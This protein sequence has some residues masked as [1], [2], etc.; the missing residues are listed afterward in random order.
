MFTFLVIQN[1]IYYMTRDDEP[2]GALFASTQ[3]ALDMG[4]VLT[5]KYECVCGTEYYPQEAIMDINGFE[6]G[7]GLLGT[8][9]HY[10]EREHVHISGE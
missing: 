3:D 1:T 10:C 7:G 6:H 9:C 4:R 2:K 8:K 5:T